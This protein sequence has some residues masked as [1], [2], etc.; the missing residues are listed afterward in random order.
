MAV[1]AGPVEC[2]ML[3]KKQSGFTLVEIMITVSVIG[4][5]ASLGAYAVRRGISNARIKEAST[6]LE[7][8]SA[9]TLQLAWDTGRW[10][11]KTIRTK[12]GSI[13]IWD[14][15]SR[16]CGLMA[17]DAIY[18]NWK[19]PYYDGATVDPW[20][21]PYFFDP[22]YRVDGKNRIVVG[23]FGPNGVGKNRYD[24]DDIYIFLDD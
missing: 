14:I 11:N 15:S 23:S 22:D 18:E 13:E 5:L 7:M 12:P 6:E 3:M 16:V 4:L 24:K 1:P 20:G 19:G 21:N 10:P 2:D 17:S 9:S 8:L